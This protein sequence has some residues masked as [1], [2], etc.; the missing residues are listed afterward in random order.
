MNICRH[1]IKNPKYNA[2]LGK[3]IKDRE[4]LIETEKSKMRTPWSINDY[5]L[6]KVNTRPPSPQTLSTQSTNTIP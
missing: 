3:K 6:I 2:K 1:L 4:I 5:P